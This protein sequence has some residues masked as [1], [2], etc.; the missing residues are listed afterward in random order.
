[1][2]LPLPSHYQVPT[3]SRV[4]QECRGKT[5]DWHEGYA[6]RPALSIGSL[7]RWELGVGRLELTRCGQSRGTDKPP[8]TL[9]TE[10][11]AY[12]MSPRSNAATT[13]PMSE[14]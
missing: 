7:C 3:P 12:G 10:P 13:R 8:S 2:V 9:M 4:A 5:H 14:G 6:F 1:M 11:V